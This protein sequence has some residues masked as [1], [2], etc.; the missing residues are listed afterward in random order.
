VV[1]PAR[2][3]DNVLALQTFDN[4]GI[5]DVCSLECKKSESLNE[6]REKHERDTRM[7]LPPQRCAC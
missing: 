6:Q 1:P 3:G 7:E 5:A 4:G 2:D